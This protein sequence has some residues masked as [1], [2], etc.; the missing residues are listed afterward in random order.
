MY[1]EDSKLFMKKLSKL[2]PPIMTL[3]DKLRNV[4][5]AE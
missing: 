2:Y 5:K 4:Q 1:Q 3:F